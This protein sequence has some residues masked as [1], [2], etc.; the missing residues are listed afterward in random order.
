[1]TTSNEEED[2]QDLKRLDPDRFLE[3][4]GAVLVHKSERGNELYVV[5]S[6][7]NFSPQAYFLRYCCPS[8][9]RV[10]VKGIRPDIGEHR[11]AD[12]AQAWSFGL[13]LDEYQ[14]LAAEA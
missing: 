7:S 8:G 14:N 11:D 9:N 6:W 12:F 10:Y 4:T 1:M 2:W 13:T 5:D 3:I